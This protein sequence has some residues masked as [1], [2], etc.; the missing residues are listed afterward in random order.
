MKDPALPGY[1]STETSTAPCISTNRCTHAMCTCP[2]PVRACAATALQAPALRPCNTSDLCAQLFGVDSA[3][4]TSY[5]YCL[6]IRAAWAQRYPPQCLSACGT[7]TH[8]HANTSKH[9][10]ATS[11]TMHTRL[12][13]VHQHNKQEGNQARVRAKTEPVYRSLGCINASLQTL[14]GSKP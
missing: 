13:W 1:G 7:Y 11:G 6:R 5:N 9:T 8:A 3:S 2:C 4:I 10:P 12:S 14:L